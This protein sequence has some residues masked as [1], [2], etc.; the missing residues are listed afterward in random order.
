[1]VFAFW[2]GARSRNKNRKVTIF[3]MLATEITAIN[4][5]ICLNFMRLRRTDRRL[6]V[7]DIAARALNCVMPWAKVTRHTASRK[8]SR[9]IVWEYSWQSRKRIYGSA[10]AGTG[11]AKECF[12]MIP[13]V[14]N[15]N[16]EVPEVTRSNKAGDMQ[17][18]LPVSRKYIWDSDP[19]QVHPPMHRG[20]PC[21]ALGEASGES[22]GMLQQE[23]SLQA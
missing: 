13:K 9:E 4:G 8:D 20:V 18:R 19:E 1:M 5:P 16:Q 2:R 12:E 3:D 6:L 11:Y 7:E 17:G 14:A 15:N 10:V 23:L 21:T 22:R